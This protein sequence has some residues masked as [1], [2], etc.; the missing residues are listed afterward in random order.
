[1]PFINRS[2]LSMDQTCRWVWSPPP[3]HTHT[4]D[5]GVQTEAA[6][7]S[8]HCIF[9]TCYNMSLALC[10][11]CCSESWMHAMRY[12]RAWCPEWNT[13]PGLRPI[14][15]CKY[16]KTYPWFLSLLKSPSANCFLVNNPYWIAPSCDDA[17]LG[18]LTPNLTEKCLTKVINRCVELLWDAI[19]WKIM[20][21]WNSNV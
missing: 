5:K 3:P 16:C 20:K 11:F 9:H 1:M 6:I 12:C 21:D 15:W 17:T 14:Q 7:D 19:L 13:L 4:I 8:I 10:C 18:L 2:P